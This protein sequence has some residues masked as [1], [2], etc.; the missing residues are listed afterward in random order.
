MSMS[1]DEMA[2]LVKQEIKGLSSNFDDDFDYSNALDDAER[3]TGWA[4]PVADGFRTYWQKERAKRHLYFYL[5]SEASEEFKVRQ[6]NL[7]QKFDHL[8][9]LIDKA[10]KDF[11]VVQESRPEEFASVDAYKSFGTQ[12]NAS[13]KYDDL[14]RDETYD[15][16]SLVTFGPTD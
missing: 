7:N 4:F 14:G 11:L 12:V 16:D 5:V 15:E 2:A 3:D 8:W 9:K 10:D 6:L 1:K 13:F